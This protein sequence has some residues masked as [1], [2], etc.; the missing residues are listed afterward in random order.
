[1]NHSL[2]YQYYWVYVMNWWKNT[3]SIFHASKCMCVVQVI[4]VQSFNQW[5]CYCVPYYVYVIVF[6]IQVFRWYLHNTARILPATR[7]NSKI[8]LK[9]HSCQDV[10]LHMQH[11]AV[12]N[13]NLSAILCHIVFSTKK[14]IQNFIPESR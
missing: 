9:Y 12:L 5:I 10:L 4:T 14:Y 8:P 2:H 1:M 3:P 11:D 7:H 6:P 13:Q